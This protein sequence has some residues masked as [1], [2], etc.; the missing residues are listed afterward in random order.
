[1][2][3]IRSD[4]AIWIAACLVLAICMM[5]WASSSLVINMPVK[6]DLI[7]VPS[8]DFTSRTG[9]ALA[10]AQQGFADLIVIDEG[11]NTLDFGRTLAERRAEQLSRSG[12]SFKVCPIHGDSTSSES[13]EAARCIVK[14]HPK[15]VLIV[16]SD[17]HTRRS[18]AMFQRAMPEISFSVAATT[19]SFSTD[20][21]WSPKSIKTTAGEW[22]GILWWKVAER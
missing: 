22:G 15:S 16:T 3:Y 12:V 4:L 14:L 11:A 18:L 8:G 20:P 7:L 9:Q 10:L 5:R 13:R 2:K 21:W 6:S 1:M 17:F 19:T